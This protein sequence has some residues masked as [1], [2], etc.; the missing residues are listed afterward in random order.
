MN[1]ST[2]QSIQFYCLALCPALSYSAAMVWKI[3]HQEQTKPMCSCSSSFRQ[4]WWYTRWQSRH[5]TT[6]RQKEYNFS[7]F[8][9]VPKCEI[10]DRSDFH[11]FYTI[12]L[13]G[14][15][16]ANQTVNKNWDKARTGTVMR[17]KKA[18]RIKDRWKATLTLRR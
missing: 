10:F 16:P 11:D 9:K 12:R 7:F 2:N 8:L 18:K 4:L 6:C 3:L 15:T 13:Y 14:R 1:Q 17:P 5:N